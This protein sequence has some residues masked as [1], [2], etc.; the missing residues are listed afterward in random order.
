MKN[1]VKIF[2]VSFLVTLY[3][4][5]ASAQLSSYDMNEPVGWATKGITPTGGTGGTSVTVTTSSELATYLAKSGKY[6]IYVKGVITVPSMIKVLVKDKTILGLS[7]SYLYSSDRTASGSGILYFKTGSNN[8]I[9]RNMTFKSAGAYDCDGND[10]FCIDGT[11]NIWV[12]H[13]DFQD[14]VDG[15]FDCKNASDYIAVT[16]CRFHY[17]IAPLAGGSGGSDDHRFSDL[18]GSSP[19]A[20]E[21]AGHLNTTFMYCWWDSGCVER[22]PRVRYG[23]IHILNC[24]YSSSVTNYCVGAGI[25][26]SIYIDNSVFNGVKNPIKD[27]SSSDEA[28][29]SSWAKFNSCIMSNCS[30][31]KSNITGGTEFNPSDYYLL[32]G[33][34]AS[35]VES[36]V[37]GSYGAGATLTV[38]EDSGVN[39]AID[40]TNQDVQSLT[41]SG[42]DGLIDLTA[43]KSQKVNIYS[44]N[45]CLIR[46][47]FIPEGSS[48][49]QLEKGFYIVN[50]KKVLV[51]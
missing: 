25:N 48:T 30:G 40:Q 15:N 13:C 38:I 39:T 16:W 28:S 50:G 21:D 32:S 9:M 51:K 11:T 4:Q 34:S 49:I 23:K 20:T 42:E 27:Y 33:T 18:F 3:T 19:S 36:A 12:D 17:L 31:T 44:I 45:G 41:I 29:G 6:I 10:N 5:V 22:M 1:I 37:T 43:T 46:T 35:N 7:G 2:L 24:Y 26:S 14:G 47:L 8:I